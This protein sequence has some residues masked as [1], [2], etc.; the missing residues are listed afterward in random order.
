MLCQTHR[1]RQTVGGPAGGPAGGVI[2]AKRSRNSSGSN[3]S[4]RVPSRNAVFSSSA[5]RPP[6]LRDA[7]LF[8]D[9]LRLEE[10]CVVLSEKPGI[11]LD[12][13]RKALDRFTAWAPRLEPSPS[14]TAR[15]GRPTVRQG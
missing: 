5:M 15:A 3:T 14:L 8:T 2:A 13:D 9:P 1:R 10:G 6:R 4:F 7:P 12:L 11:G